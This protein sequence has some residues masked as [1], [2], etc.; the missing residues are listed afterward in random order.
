MSYFYSLVNIAAVYGALAALQVLLLNRLGLAF[1]AIPVFAGLGAYI[2]A[3]WAVGAPVS[4]GMFA[5]VVVLAVVISWLANY[6]PRDHYLL[7]TIA[8]VE[9]LGAAVGLSETLGGREGLP[10]PEGWSV[11]GRGFEASML[12]WTLGSLI[13]IIVGIRLLL[14]SAAGAAIDRLR[15]NPEAAPRFFP[16]RHFRVVVVAGC[17]TA[18]TALGVLY[19]AYQG[20]VS[21]TVFSLDFALL[22]LAFTVMAYRAPEVAGLAALLY[23]VLPYVMT[24]ALPLSQQGAADLIRFIW[25][26]LL[27]AA[28]VVPHVVRTQRQ[29]RGARTQ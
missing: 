1:A 21:P 12:V 6:L 25:G 2:V 5:L 22:L 8:A 28:I 23:W 9:C 24:K 20:R 16:A 26:G 17:V 15:E 29:L 19:L 27:V 14:S 13:V 11:G 3:A 4:A 18:A 7:C 10:I